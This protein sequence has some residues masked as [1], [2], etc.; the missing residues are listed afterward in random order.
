MDTDHNRPERVLGRI[1]IGNEVFS[2]VIA[3]VKATEN[4]IRAVDP[5]ERDNRKADPEDNNKNRRRPI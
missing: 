1:R 2:G 5:P 3:G 4:I